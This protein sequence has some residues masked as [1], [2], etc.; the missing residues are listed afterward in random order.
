L[1][2]NDTVSVAS[3]SVALVLPVFVIDDQDRVLV[4]QRGDGVGDCRDDRQLLFD[5]LIGPGV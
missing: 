5:C 1:Q 4:G 3:C 2:E